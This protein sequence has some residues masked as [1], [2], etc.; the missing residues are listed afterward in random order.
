MLFFGGVLVSSLLVGGYNPGQNIWR[1]CS[2]SAKK[3]TPQAKGNHCLRPFV[4][5]QVFRTW[6]RLKT[7]GLMVEWSGE[8]PSTQFPTETSVFR[9]C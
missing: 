1:K 8:Q 5:N 7:Y 9:M 3:P 6:L 2:I 4:E